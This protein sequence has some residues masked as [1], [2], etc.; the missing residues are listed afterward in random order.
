VGRGSH[1]RL[2]TD[3]GGDRVGGRFAVKWFLT[4]DVFFLRKGLSVEGA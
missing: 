3:G 1:G 2:S 4:Q